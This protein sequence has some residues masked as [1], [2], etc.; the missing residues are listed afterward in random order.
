MFCSPRF[1]LRR[2]MK[3]T[4]LIIH[5]DADH[6]TMTPDEQARIVGLLMLRVDYD[7]V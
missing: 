6:Q 4:P 5:P 2:R 3:R 7:G 1:A